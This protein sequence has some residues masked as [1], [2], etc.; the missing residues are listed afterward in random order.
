[1]RRALD[2]A[3]R[4]FRWCWSQIRAATDGGGADAEGRDILDFQP[5]LFDALAALEDRH[6]A[7]RAA[8]KRLIKRK[9]HLDPSWFAR[10]MKRLASY[11]K[12]IEHGLAIGRAIGD[13][14]AWIFYER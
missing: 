6:H 2:E 13:G 10:R 9:R 8:E 4:E 11:R 5:R 3:E 12:L 1:V 7:I 14:F